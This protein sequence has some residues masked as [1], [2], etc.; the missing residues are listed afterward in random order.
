M[1][2]A[3]FTVT[4]TNGVSYSADMLTTGWRLAGEPLEGMESTL[5]FICSGEMKTV[6][7]LDVKRIEFHP[8]GTTHCNRCD[9]SVWGMVGF[10]P[11]KNPEPAC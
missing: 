11:F 3:S 6:S 1:R 8:Y 10:G 4:L 9:G 7:A 2:Q 5:S